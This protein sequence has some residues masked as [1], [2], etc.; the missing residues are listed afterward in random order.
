MSHRGP[1]WAPLAPLPVIK[2]LFEWIAMDFIGSLPLT[3]HSAR[4]LLVIIDYATRYPEAIPLPSMKS[5]GMARALMHFFSHVGLPRK[6]LTEQGTPFTA[7]A[8]KEMCEGLHSRSPPPDRR[9]S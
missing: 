5:P 2:K 7:T 9:I 3:Q 6:I 4:Y 1:L 8:M